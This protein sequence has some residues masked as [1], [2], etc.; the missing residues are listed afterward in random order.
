M[1]KI[2]ESIQSNTEKHVSFAQM[3]PIP[4]CI[5]YTVLLLHCC[6][7]VRYN[8]RQFCISACILHGQLINNLHACYNYYY[9]DDNILTYNV[10]ACRVHELITC[11]TFRVCYGVR[12]QQVY[13]TESFV[14]YSS[15]KEHYYK[16]CGLFGLGRCKRT[17]Y[18]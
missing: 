2:T 1:Q 13:H 12:H 17:R 15:V 8:T 18:R 9:T 5:L 6:K 16:A 14:V 3:Y 4:Y 7:W 10:Y 11:I